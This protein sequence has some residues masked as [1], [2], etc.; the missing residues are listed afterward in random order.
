MVENSRV[1]RLSLSLASSQAF[2]AFVG[3]LLVGVLRKMG[4]NERGDSLKRVHAKEVRVLI[5][6]SS[7]KTN[8]ILMRKHRMLK[9]LP[10]L[11]RLPPHPR[12]RRRNRTRKTPLKILRIIVM[13]L[14]GGRTMSRD[15]KQLTSIALL[16]S[17]RTGRPQSRVTFAQAAAMLGPKVPNSAATVV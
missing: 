3:I 12:S 10:P 7:R 6:D 13:K 5:E 9:F 4:K 14:E 16:L 15:E 1:T 11:L 8:N 17:S 2:F